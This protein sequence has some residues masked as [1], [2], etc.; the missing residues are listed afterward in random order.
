MEN[1]SDIVSE[2]AN[3]NIS[4][5]API[6]SS[7]NFDLGQS[8]NNVHHD[9]RSNTGEDGNLLLQ[10][11]AKFASFFFINSLFI[12]KV[13]LIKRSLRTVPGVFCP[14]ALSMCSVAVFMRIGFVV[15]NSGFYQSIGLYILTFSIFVFTG[16]SVCAISTNGA[17]EGGGV[18]CKSSIL[19]QILLKV[20]TILSLIE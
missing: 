15:G 6:L 13:S 12:L 9:L 8:H 2:V 4:D 7:R 1:N 17:I 16:L 20:F 5:S 14:V 19:F 18:Y 10:Y 11:S 3:I